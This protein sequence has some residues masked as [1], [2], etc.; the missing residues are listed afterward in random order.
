MA[1]ESARILGAE[2]QVLLPQKKAFV[3]EIVGW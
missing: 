3:E 1:L 2:K